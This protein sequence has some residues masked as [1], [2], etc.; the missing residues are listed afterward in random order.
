[1]KTT[2]KKIIA[3][4]LYNTNFKHLESWFK[5]LTILRNKC[6]HY[7]RLYFLKFSNYP[8]LPKNSDL[9]TNS[10][11]FGQILLLK[12]LHINDN[13]WN[14]NFVIPMESLLEEYSK[15]IRFGNIG[16]PENWKKILSK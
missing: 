11:L 7:S 4:N 13:N 9:K 3:R 1:M 10:R 14:N 12:F 6:A 16:F 5:C 8:K 15:Y 2:D